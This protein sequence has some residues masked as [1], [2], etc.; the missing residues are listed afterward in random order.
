MAEKSTIPLPVPSE[1][2]NFDDQS[3]TRRTIEQAIQD[4][5]QEIGNLKTLQQSGVSKA[6]KRHSFLLMGMQHG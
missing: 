5:N 4:I 3:F 1:D 6:I 2:Y